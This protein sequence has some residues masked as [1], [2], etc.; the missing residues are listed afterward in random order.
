M[1]KQYYTIVAIQKI[2]AQSTYFSVEAESEEE[3]EALCRTGKVDPD[4]QESYDH[5][6][7]EWGEMLS[8]TLE[9]PPPKSNRPRAKRRKGAS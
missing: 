1:A 2:Y 7:D 3:A 5:G 4:L 9:E 6:D 8:I